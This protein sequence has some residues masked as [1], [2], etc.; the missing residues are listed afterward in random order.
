MNR[1]ALALGLILCGASGAAVIAPDANAQ[2]K[3]IIDRLLPTVIQV[4]GENEQGTATSGSGVLLG[5]GLA[6]T[7]LHAAALPS[8]GGM[9]PVSRLEVLVPDAG[10]V[11]ARVLDVL[12]DLDLAILLLSEKGPPMAGAPLATQMPDEGN[13]LIAMGTAD[14]T[15]EARGMVVSQ[16]DGELFTLVG[17][18]ATDSRFWGGPLFDGQGRIVGIQLTSV[19]GAKAVSA[20]VIQRILD[21][22]RLNRGPSRA[23]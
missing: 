10:T 7:T 23:Q 14:D 17:K 12:P 15:I 13:Q 8:D 9:V 18:R 16:I 6:V 19:S 1:R 21:R 20:K 4:R 22:H 2:W 3:A 5:N 11:G